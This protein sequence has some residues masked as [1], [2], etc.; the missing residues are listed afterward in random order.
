MVDEGTSTAVVLA[1]AKVCVGRLE[2]FGVH[3]AHGKMPE[4]RPDVFVDLGEIAAPRAGFGIEHLQPTVQQLIEGGRGPR[5][6]LFVDLAEQSGED[7]LRLRPGART[8]TNSLPKV[9]A[10]LRHRIDA[11]VDTHTQSTGRQLLD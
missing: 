5:V 3:S 6:A 9:E 2:D 7:L 8:G 11:P 10:A 1:L 4:D